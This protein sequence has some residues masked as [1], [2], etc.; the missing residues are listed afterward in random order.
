MKFICFF[1]VRGFI[2]KFEIKYFFFLE[3]IIVVFPL[4]LVIKTN[5]Y[6]T[7][8]SPLSPKFL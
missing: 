5:N 7:L 6:F 8:V 3:F 1:I 2:I 4:L